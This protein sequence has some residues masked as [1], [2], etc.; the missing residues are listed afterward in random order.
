MAWRRWIV[1]AWLGGVGSLRHGLEANDPAR[2]DLGMLESVG[3][4][5]ALADQRRLWQAREGFVRHGLEAND[6]VRRDLGM[7]ESVGVDKALADQRRLG[8][9]YR[10]DATM[11]LEICLAHSGGRFISKGGDDRG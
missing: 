11:L 2:R 3:V 8:R 4:G 6:P 10:F 1:E 7:L 9:G 5:K